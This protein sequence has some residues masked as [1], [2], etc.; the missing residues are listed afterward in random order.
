MQ[1]HYTT[2]V[3]LTNTLFVTQSLFSAAQIAIITL[4]SIVAV[5]LS[6]SDANAGIPSTVLTLAQS[7][8]ALPLGIVMGRFG[9]RLGLSVA[10]VM[11]VLGALLGVV[12]LVTGSFPLLLF[13]SGLIGVGR[14]GADQSRYAAGDMFPESERGRMIGRIVLAGTVGAILGP[15][16]VV[17]GGRLAA[18]VG[19]PAD[20]GPWLVALAFFTWA[21]MITF[22][23]LRPDPMQIARQIS[24]DPA[25]RKAKTGD[26]TRENVDNGRGLREL[27]SLPQVQLG[28]LSMLIS[29]VVM[30]TLMVMTPLYMSHH[31]H[32]NDAI[33]IVIMAHTLGMFGLSA[34]TGRLIDR[35]GRERM[36]VVAGVVLI[37]STLIAP[38]STEMPVLIVGLFLLGLGW[39]FGYIAGSSLLADALRGEERSRVQG[40]S[41]MLVAFAAALGTLSAGP[42]FGFGGYMLVAALG[43]VLTLLL[44]WIV[45]LLAP[46]TAPVTA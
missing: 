46:H 23:G 10:Y 38:L 37:I 1:D 36:M 3:R 18:S 30:V 14:A 28:V 11:S 7:A 44:L 5:D 42:V 13:S 15:L 17:P 24:G 39:N 6:G 35:Y 40:A 33:S 31:D 2:G 19:L 43:L 27:F 41:D 12:A 32:G 9:R 34:L 22:A 45:R 8:A 20:S 26:N 21:L 29:Q 25:K 4:L 16:L